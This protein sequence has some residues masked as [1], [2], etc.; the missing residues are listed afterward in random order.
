M[1]PHEYHYMKVVCTFCKE[2][3]HVILRQ[4]LI[5]NEIM[6]AFPFNQH[7]IKWWYLFSLASRREKIISQKH[8][9]GS[10]VET[11]APTLSQLYVIQIII[12]NIIQPNA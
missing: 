6:P 7:M 10:W 12:I 3:E 5:L 2:A 11:E 8:L 4:P 1:Y 9:K